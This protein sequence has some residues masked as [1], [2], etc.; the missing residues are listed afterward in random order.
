M[1]RQLCFHSDSCSRKSIRYFF[2]QL[3]KASCRPLEIC[4][5]TDGLSVITKEIFEF[6]FPAYKGRKDHPRTHRGRTSN[7]SSMFAQ[8]RSQFY[9]THYAIASSKFV[10]A[11][12]KKILTQLGARIF[13]QKF[14][15]KLLKKMWKRKNKRKLVY[16]L[17]DDKETFFFCVRTSRDGGL[18]GCYSRMSYC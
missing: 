2:R 5:Q 17:N 18:Q 10:W 14:V 16:R 15:I 11:L 3:T 4:E 12:A 6:A 1:H 13:N 9:G 8:T 7:S